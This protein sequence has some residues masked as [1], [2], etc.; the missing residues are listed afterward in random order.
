M[1]EKLKKIECSESSTLVFDLIGNSSFRFE[2]FDGSL[3]IPFKHAGRYHLARKIAACPLPVYKRILENT[4][5]VLTV[6]QQAKVVIVPPLPRYLFSGCCKQTGHST[7]VGEPGHSNTLL[8]DTIGL[9]NHL[10]KFVVSLGIKRCLV[11]DSCCVA[12]CPTTA[13]LRHAWMP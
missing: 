6:H 2:Q 4:V 8:S 1:A 10:K 3:L 11:M 13:K 9:R 7:N 5:L 12:D